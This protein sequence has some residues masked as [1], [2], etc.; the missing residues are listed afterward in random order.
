MSSECGVSVSSI[1]YDPTVGPTSFNLTQV[2][3][4]KGLPHANQRQVQFSYYDG[5]ATNPG[6]TPSDGTLGIFTKGCE[7]NALI[8]DIYDTD[9]KLVG[10]TKIDAQ[11]ST[12]GSC[13]YRNIDAEW[14]LAQV[15]PDAV[16]GLSDYSYNFALAYADK[17]GNVFFVTNTITYDSE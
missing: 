6:P 13:L 5:S 9:G 3:F 12:P 1:T 11:S 7:L 17:C 15:S 16:N 2:Y 14:I 4:Q 8:Q 10:R